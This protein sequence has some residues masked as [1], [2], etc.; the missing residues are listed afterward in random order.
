M[1]RHSRPISIED[2]KAIQ[3]AHGKQ[4]THMVHVGW[5]GFTIAHTDDERANGDRLEDCA[6]HLWME[7][8]AGPP[9]APGIYLVTEQDGDP[10]A[11]WFFDGP[12]FDG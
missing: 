8:Q 2:L 3:A 12:Q 10:V 7:S 6:F 4:D 5:R 11:P 9:V 1:A